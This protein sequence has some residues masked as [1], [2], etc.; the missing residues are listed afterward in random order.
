MAHSNVYLVISGKELLVVDTGTPGNAKKI[1]DYIQKIGYQP[2]DV[3]NIVLT[4]FHMDHAGSA[5]ELK[6]LLPNAKV[7]A[8]KDDAEYIEGKKPL[9]KPRNVLFRAVSSFVKVQPVQVDLL[10]KEGDRVGSLTVI[11]VPGHTPGSIALL[12]GER[13]ILFAGDTLRFDGKNVSGGSEQF[14]ADPEG[15]R[16][17]IGKLSALSFSVMLPGHGEVLRPDASDAV[18]KFYESL[19]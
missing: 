11:H 4:H 12:D 3:A 15:A 16:Q 14:T 6:E 18:K 2:S 7:A 13:K 1:V 10:L 8:H 9:P 5:K 19:K 17:S